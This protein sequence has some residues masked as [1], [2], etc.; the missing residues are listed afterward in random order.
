MFHNPK[1]SIGIPIFNREKYIEECAVS[2]FEQSYAN[3]EYIFVDD[4]STDRS[5]EILIRTIEKYP[6]RK[7]QTKIITHEKNMGLWKAR[8][9]SMD[10]MTGDYC[11]FCDADDWVEKD[12]YKIMMSKL[13]DEDLDMVVSSFFENSEKEQKIINVTDDLFNDLNNMPIDILHFAFWNKL[14]KREIIEDN[15]LR[16]A[17]NVNCWED[18]CVTAKYMAI[19]DKIGVVE[20]PLYHYRKE[21]QKSLTS[22]DHK[23]RL[24]DQLK[25]TAFVV[26]WFLEN[27]KDSQIKYKDFLMHL[28]FV[29]KI[30]M[31][32]GKEKNVEDWKNTYPE[33]N[34]DIL[35]YG[36]I[37]LHYRYFFYII[38]KL[39]TSVSNYLINLF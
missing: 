5:V 21:Q 7:S 17:K 19:T 14:F 39:P 20:A 9:S 2:L 12:A 1:I 26:D 35:K 3:L 31:L 38:D 30:K 11:A 10:N 18:V 33:S 28:K 6:N 4:G 36:F 25:A 8:N 29:S 24:T 27:G 16:V 32:R 37:P 23:K 34:K 15:N 22:L 13:I